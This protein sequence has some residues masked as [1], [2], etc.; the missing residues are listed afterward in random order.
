MNWIVICIYLSL[1]IFAIWRLNSKEGYRGGRGGRD[2]SRWGKG[3]YGNPIPPGNRWGP[4][5]SYWG[6]WGYGQGYYP[7]YPYGPTCPLRDGCPVPG[8]FGEQGVW[9]TPLPYLCSYGLCYN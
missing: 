7:Y 8:Y 3:P 6:G 4:Y 5:S 1:L 9:G 2:R